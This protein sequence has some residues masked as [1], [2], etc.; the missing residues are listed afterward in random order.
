MLLSGTIDMKNKEKYSLKA[1]SYLIDTID[2][3]M[4]EKIKELE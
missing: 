2:K 4:E 1:K 3:L